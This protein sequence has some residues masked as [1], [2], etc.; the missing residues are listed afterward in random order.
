MPTLEAALATAPA[1]RLV[2]DSLSVIVSQDVD[3][4]CAVTV[5]GSSVQL[6]PIHRCASLAEAQAYLASGA[7]PRVLGDELDWKPASA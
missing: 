1:A 4:E 7:V 5:L 6:G 3:G 2:R